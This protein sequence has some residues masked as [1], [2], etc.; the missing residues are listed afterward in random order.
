MFTET[1]FHLIML[2]HRAYIRKKV[3]ENRLKKKRKR[4]NRNKHIQTMEEQLFHK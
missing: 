4:Q 2:L 3:K 1:D